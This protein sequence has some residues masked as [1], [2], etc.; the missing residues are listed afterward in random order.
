MGPPTVPPKAQGSHFSKRS[1]KRTDKAPAA[2]GVPHWREVGGVARHEPAHRRGKR[3][4][5][6]TGPANL[7]GKAD[8]EGISPTLVATGSA[9]ES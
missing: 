2:T 4:T 9:L 6:L 8:S 1:G 7:S 3:D 5:G